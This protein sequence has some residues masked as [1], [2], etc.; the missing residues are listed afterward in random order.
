MI[1]NAILN[2]LTYNT[3]NI[4]I[5]IMIRIWV[6]IRDGDSSLTSPT[7]SVQ[8]DCGRLGRLVVGTAHGGLPSRSARSNWRTGGTDNATMPSAA[9]RPTSPGD[10]SCR[11]RRRQKL[12]MSGQKTNA[13]CHR[14]HRRGHRS[15]SD[16]CLRLAFVSI[17]ARAELARCGGCSLFWGWWKWQRKMV[18]MRVCLNTNEPD[19]ESNTTPN[20]T[21]SATLLT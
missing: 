19:I 16:T 21:V 2:R 17:F 1:T 13:L 3:I 7:W 18:Q 20:R 9:A 15:V 10:R 12:L 11:R 8:C 4:M 5:I 6:R 14:R